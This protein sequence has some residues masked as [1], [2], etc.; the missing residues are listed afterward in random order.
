[1]MS[2]YDTNKNIAKY[3]D[4]V[5]MVE[6]LGFMPLSNNCIDFINLA[7][8]TVKEEWHTGLST[9]PWLW[10]LRIEQDSKAAYAKLFDKKPGFISPEWYPKF[11]AARRKGR[12]FSQMY[13]EG[14]LSNYAK[15]IYRLFESNETLAVHEIKSLGGFTK[16]LNAKYESAMSELQMGMFITVKGTKQKV[17]A[18][19]EPYGW[20]STAY[21]TVE[22]WAGEK[23]MEEANQLKPED[24][25]DAILLKIKD[26]TPNAEPRKLKR[27]MGF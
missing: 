23:L 11:I 18:K 19:G 13:S 5:S 21:S 16:E 14:L 15:Q 1:M 4:F 3:S 26:I 20:P 27:F 17:S 9:D 2:D 22:A 24:A 8:L 10:R 25:M 6:D 12:S 7:D